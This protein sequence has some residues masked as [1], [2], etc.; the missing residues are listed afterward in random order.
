MVIW[1]DYLKPKILEERQVKFS[2]S[3]YKN[4]IN[5]LIR[6]DPSFVEVRYNVNP[7]D[8]YKCQTGLHC[9]IAKRYGEGVHF[10]IP[11]RKFGI[12]KSK[13]Y[14]TKDEFID[15]A[16]NVNDLILDNIWEELKYFIKDEKTEGLSG[17]D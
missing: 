9:S 7:P 11:N 3:F 16:L 15:N 17:W 2:K 6:D 5:Q 4:I 13:H 10:L 12:G 14:C 8:T 1:N